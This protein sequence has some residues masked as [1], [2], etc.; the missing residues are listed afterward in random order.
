MEAETGYSQHSG[1]GPIADGSAEAA[2]K[3]GRAT[4]PPA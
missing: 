3:I 2:E 1:I 4:P